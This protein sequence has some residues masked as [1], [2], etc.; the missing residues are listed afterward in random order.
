M[1]ASAAWPRGCYGSG[2]NTSFT[3]QGAT[4]MK[5]PTQKTQKPARRDLTLAHLELATGGTRHPHPFPN[6]D[7]F[8]GWPGEGI[9]E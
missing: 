7:E 1:D 3:Q 4:T 5:K 2:S 8:H 9:N 6:P